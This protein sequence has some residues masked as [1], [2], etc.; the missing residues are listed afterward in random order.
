MLWPVS[1]Y[2][3][4]NFISKHFSSRVEEK[5][6]RAWERAGLPTTPFAGTTMFDKM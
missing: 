6:L 1:F 5:E 3:K 4:S 2:Q